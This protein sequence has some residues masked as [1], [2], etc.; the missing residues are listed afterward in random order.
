[1]AESYKCAVQNGRVGSYD[2]TGDFS[3]GDNCRH[4]PRS[5][6][7]NKFS[8]GFAVWSVAYFASAVY[9]TRLAVEY[10]TS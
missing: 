7:E 6:L 5:G 3:I 10:L 8:V 4:C 2:E 1:M 9:L